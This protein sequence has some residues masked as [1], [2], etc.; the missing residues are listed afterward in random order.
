M[1]FAHGNSY[2]D[3]QVQ[4]RQ[5]YE[6]EYSTASITEVPK[7]VWAEVAAW[8]QRTLD[9]FYSVIFLDAIHFT[10]HEGENAVKKA[11]YSMYAVDDQ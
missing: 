7:Q 8:Q 11:V 4:L 5:L 1:M 10:T 3:I 6:M 9:C 2:G